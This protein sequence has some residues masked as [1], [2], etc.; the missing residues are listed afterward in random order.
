MRGFIDLHLQRSISGVDELELMLRLAAEMGYC[1]VGVALEGAIPKQLRNL[2]GELGLDLISRIDL[3]PRT[4]RELRDGLRMVR[5]SFEVVAVY[6]RNKAVARQAAKDH[7]VDLLVFPSSIPTRTRVWFDRQE[8]NLASGASCAYEINSSYLLGTGPG[9]CS[10]LLSIIRSEIR[11][12]RRH[13]VPVVASSGSD[14]RL[15]MREPLG[16]AAL[17]HLVDIGEEEGLDMISYIPR[18]MVEANRINLFAGFIAPGV[19]LVEGD[20]R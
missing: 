1:G 4:A 8:A 9:A 20:A 11:N 13:D 17:L 15:L 5:R 12:A 19:R 3:R 6:C 10:R 16:I 18:K 14:S 2:C 7:R